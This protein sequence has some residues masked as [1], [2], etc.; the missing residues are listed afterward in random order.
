MLRH[1]LLPI[2]AVSFLAVGCGAP[3]EQEASN[4]DIIVGGESSLAYYNADDRVS[5]SIGRMARGCTA[6]HIGKLC[7]HRRTLCANPEL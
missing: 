3:S 5:R 4:L 2:M 7:T 1:T 6:T